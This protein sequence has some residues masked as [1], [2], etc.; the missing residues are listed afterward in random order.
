MKFTF[1]SL[2]ASFLAFAAAALNAATSSSTADILRTLFCFL[3][4]DFV[5]IPLVD[6]ESGANASP[7]A[8]QVSKVMDVSFI[9]VL[10]TR[11]VTL[12]NMFS[13]LPFY[14]DNSDNNTTGG[15]I[16]LS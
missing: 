14:D 1:D 6:N 8:A 3:I 2:D 4:Q 7:T 10:D 15:V 5:A 12:V 13:S 9:V 16:I 11:Y